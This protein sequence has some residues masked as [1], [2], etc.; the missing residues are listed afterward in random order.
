MAD[1]D[2]IV[3]LAGLQACEPDWLAECIKGQAG[4]ALSVL[5]SVLIALRAEMPETFAF[6]EMLRAPV[7]MQSLTGDTDFVPRPCTDVDVGIV[8]ERLQH[9][10]LKKISKDVAHQAVEIRAMNAGFIPCATIWKAWNRT[11]CRGSQVCSRPISGVTTPN[12][13]ERSARCS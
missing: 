3:R 10:G 6:D 9:L 13:P 4:Q 2:N 8:Q 7:L 5:A 1:V 11:A 12:T